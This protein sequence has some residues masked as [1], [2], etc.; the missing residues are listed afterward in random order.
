MRP[1]VTS[2]TRKKQVC[3]CLNLRT[4]PTRSC[5]FVCVVLSKKKKKKKMRANNL[6]N[7]EKNYKAE[8][9]KESKDQP[10]LV[11]CEESQFSV[12]SFLKTLLVLAS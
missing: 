5:V 1:G 10:K 7:P 3:P 8:V 11:V 9:L 4:A 12:C 2:R 6:K